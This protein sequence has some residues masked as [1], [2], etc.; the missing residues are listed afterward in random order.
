M[1]EPMRVLLVSDAYPP[2]IGGAT[3]AA[4]QLGRQLTLRGHRVQVAT[5]WQRDLPVLGR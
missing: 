3:R 2:I 4:Q 5:A 1:A